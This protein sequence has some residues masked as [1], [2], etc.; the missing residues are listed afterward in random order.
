MR[1][2]LAQAYRLPC[3]ALKAWIQQAQADAGAATL[4][5]R[6]EAMLPYQSAAMGSCRFMYAGVCDTHVLV[7]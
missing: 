3:E 5:C 1:P 6:S 2:S 7:R 4:M